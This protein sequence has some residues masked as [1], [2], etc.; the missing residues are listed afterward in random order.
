VCHSTDVLS[1]FAQRGKRQSDGPGDTGREHRL[2]GELIP[3]A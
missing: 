2:R 3:A 1:V